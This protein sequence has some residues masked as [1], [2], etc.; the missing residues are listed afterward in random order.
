MTRN[1]PSSEESNN[2]TLNQIPL[3]SVCIYVY[4]TCNHELIRDCFKVRLYVTKT[5]LIL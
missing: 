1:E 3:D 4:R 5:P 2:Q